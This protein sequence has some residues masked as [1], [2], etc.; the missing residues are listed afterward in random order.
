MCYVCYANTVCP[1]HPWTMSSGRQCSPSCCTVLRLGPASV[2]QLNAKD[3]TRSYADASDCDTVT[4]TFRRWWK[5]LRVTIGL[6]LAESYETTSMCCSITCQNVTNWSITWDH[7]SIASNY[8]Q[9]RLNLTTVTILCGCC[10]KMHIET[11]HAQMTCF[12]WMTLLNLFIV[13]TAMYHYDMYVK[14][15][16]DNFDN[17]RRYDD[18]DDDVKFMY[19]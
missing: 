5:C 11:T 15:A 9:R 7:G 4:T 1:A 17:K 13:Q 2:W 19:R 14:V 8:F 16:F 12:Q 10:I 3:S 18:D 6:C